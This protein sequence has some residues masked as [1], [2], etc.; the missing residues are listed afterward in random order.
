[1]SSAFVTMFIVPLRYMVILGK[2]ILHVCQ[3]DGTKQQGTELPF[4]QA[5]N[6]TCCAAE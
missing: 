4:G 5:G 1:M 2:C 3:M 6:F